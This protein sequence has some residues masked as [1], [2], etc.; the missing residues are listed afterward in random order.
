MSNHNKTE[1]IATNT[2]LIP[3]IPP[4]FYG[5]D[6]AMLLIHDA[7]AAFG[8]L[9]KFVQMKGF[10]RLMLIFQE[11]AHAMKAKKALDRHYIIW[12][13]RQPFPEI[14]TFTKE[15]DEVKWK[16]HE[17]L[18]IRVYYGQVKKENSK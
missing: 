7:F 13:E 1:S 9:F 10:R 5:C 2:L 8:P 17:F 6:D 15:K 11:T 18:E 12:R 16:D 3:D 4:C 14:I